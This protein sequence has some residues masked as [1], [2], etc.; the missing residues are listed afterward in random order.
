MNG[1]KIY[2]I[3]IS[4]GSD[5]GYSLDYAPTIT[6]A[7]NGNP[8]SADQFMTSIVEGTNSDGFWNCNNFV[9]IPVASEEEA[10]E[11]SVYVTF[12]GDGQTYNGGIYT[13]EDGVTY[14]AHFE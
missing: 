14:G 11:Y 5:L 9:L 4:A 2:Q 8:V 6:V 12:V 1:Y 13:L 3:S 10:E 7:K